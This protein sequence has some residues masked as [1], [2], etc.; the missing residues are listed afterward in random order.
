MRP[1][2]DAS[3][4]ALDADQDDYKLLNVWKK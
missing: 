2:V 3:Q 4:F 1:F